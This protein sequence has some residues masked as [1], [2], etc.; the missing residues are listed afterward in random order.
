MFTVREI[1]PLGEK[2]TRHGPHCEEAWRVLLLTLS[3]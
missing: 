3:G 2:M 1:E